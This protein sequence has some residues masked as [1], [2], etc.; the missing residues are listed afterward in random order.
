MP[1][2]RRLQSST[3]SHLVKLLLRGYPHQ[4]CHFPYRY[5]ANSSAINTN[6]RIFAW[7]STPPAW[8]HVICCVADCCFVLCSASALS[9]HVWQLVKQGHSLPFVNNQADAERALSGVVIDTDRGPVITFTI[10]DHDEVMTVDEVGKI[11]SA[12]FQRLYSV[13]PIHRA[14]LCIAC[15]SRLLNLQPYHKTFQRELCMQQVADILAHTMFL[16]TPLASRLYGGEVYVKQCS[17]A[18]TG[19][20]V[21]VGDQTTKEVYI[22]RHM[23]ANWEHVCW[24]YQTVSTLHQLRTC[25]DG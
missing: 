24:R 12:T 3:S 16:I 7:V 9:C 21:C 1:C 8:S 2:L 19:A 25:T 17:V 14:T 20:L 13:R 11:S 4:P 18:L 5:V 10:E 6:S 23:H 15:V 22:C